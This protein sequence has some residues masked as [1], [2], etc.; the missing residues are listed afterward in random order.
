M[1]SAGE[2]ETGDYSQMRELLSLKHRTYIFLIIYSQ[3][4]QFVK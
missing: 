1:T 3:L 2:K 4:S